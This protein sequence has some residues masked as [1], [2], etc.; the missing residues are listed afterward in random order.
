MQAMAGNS[1]GARLRA[2]RQAGISLAEYDARRAAGQK[3]CMRCQ[4]WHAVARFGLDRSRSDGLDV[5]CL[6]SGIVAAGKPGVRE[7]RLQADAGRAWCRG[8][9]GWLLKE[10]VSQGV[11]REH[12]NAEYRAR[13]ARNPEVIRAQKYARRR[14]LDP[15]PPWWADD[16]L[17]EFD[18]LC[19]YG[20][21][22]EASTWDHVWP[23]S[24]GGRSHAANL[25]PACG[26]CNS[27][28][29][30]GYPWPWVERG[31]AVFPQAW[32]DLIALG[33]EVRG[34]EWLEEPA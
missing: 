7:R 17:A 3:R 12:A 28:K 10:D 16:R 13:Y 27:R 22:R 30:N 29:G 6:E 25:V 18:S 21:G 4:D 26:S 34:V 31:Y 8:C 23:V 5:S 9:R 11:C 20:C 19:A 2:A 33:L 1:D 14:C 24:L 32:S 15:I